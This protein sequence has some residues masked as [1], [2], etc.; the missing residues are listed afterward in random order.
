MT[1]HK[2]FMFPIIENEGCTGSNFGDLKG[3][4]LM[5][6]PSRKLHDPMDD[7]VIIT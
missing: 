6:G 4:I 3:E 2:P 5:T 1:W 7:M